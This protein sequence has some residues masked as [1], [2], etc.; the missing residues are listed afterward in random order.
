MGGGM[1]NTRRQSGLRHQGWR[2][3]GEFEFLFDEKI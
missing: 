1:D 2:E 3:V